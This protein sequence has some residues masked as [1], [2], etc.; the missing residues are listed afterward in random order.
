[1][2]HFISNTCKTE[3]KLMQLGECKFEFAIFVSKIISN[4][5]FASDKFWFF[6]LLIIM[7]KLHIL[8]VSDAR[9]F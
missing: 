4:H 1:M 3:F 6:D 7:C 8:S 9:V 5:S 2:F